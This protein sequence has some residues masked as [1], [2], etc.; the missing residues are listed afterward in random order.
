MERQ[1]K[2]LTIRLPADL[3][4]D[5]RTIAELHTRSLNGE[6]LVA[7]RDYVAKYK[8]GKE[9]RLKPQSPNPVD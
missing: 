2:T 8:R 6:C 5:M 1:E 3:L 9:Q 4:A 7:L